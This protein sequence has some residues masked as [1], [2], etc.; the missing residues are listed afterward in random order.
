MNSRKNQLKGFIQDGLIAQAIEMIRSAQG[1]SEREVFVS[2]VLR[3]EKSPPEELVKAMLEA[4]LNTRKNYHNEHIEWVH[5]L[6]HFNKILWE[7]RMDEWI[8]KFNEVAF[9]GANEFEDFNC[10]DRIVDD[11]ADHAKWNDDPADFHITPENLVLIKWCEY[12]K[13]TRAR[14]KEG[15]FESEEA[16]CR[17]DLSHLK[18][19]FAEYDDQS[20]CAEKI[21]NII[22]RLQQLNADTSKF[23]DLQKEMSLLLAKT[24]KDAE[25][26]LLEETQ[27]LYRERLEKE[28][29][30]I[31]KVLK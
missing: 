10:S 31:R 8:K 9:K 13:D 18:T 16:F 25:E 23:N 6:S 19:R 7:R 4:F 14:I 29:K 3:E 26:E 24:L 20:V 28:I 30:K 12:N 17:W 21:L 5:S 2:A 22:Q 27:D 15:R 11:F 1:Y